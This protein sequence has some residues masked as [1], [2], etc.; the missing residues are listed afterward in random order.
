[1]PILSNMKATSETNGSA[2]LGEFWWTVRGNKSY[3]KVIRIQTFQK[4]TW[5]QL[6]KYISLNMGMYNFQISQ[7]FVAWSK[8]NPF[9]SQL[10]AP[11]PWYTEHPV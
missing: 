8:Y 10:E 7:W 5:P 9:F 1:M 3:Q 6:T 2:G 4:G 11:C